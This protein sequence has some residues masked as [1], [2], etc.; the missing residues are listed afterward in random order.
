[1]TTHRVAPGTV[2][3]SV[4]PPGSK[5]Y[6][7]R[8]AVL[9]SQ[10]TAPVVLERPLVSEDTLATRRALVRLGARIARTGTNW[11]VQPSPSRHRSDRRTLV[12]DCGES[13]TTFRFLAALAAVRPGT[14]AL[15]GSRRL[16]ARPIEPLLETLRE[17]GARCRWLRG[18]RGLEITGPIRPGRFRLN[19]SVSSQFTSAL[20]LTLPFL[21]SP[22]RVDL[23]GDI[24][25][26]P[27]VAASRKMLNAF[28]LRVRGTGR[29]LAVPAPQRIRVRK[30]AIPADASS[31]A[32]WWVAAAITGGRIETYGVR[33][34]PPQADLRVL[35]VLRRCGVRVVRDSDG[36]RVGGRLLRGF[37][38]DLTEAPDLYPLLVVLAVYAPRP[39]EI[40]GAPHVISKESDR[41][42][43][44]IR[45]ATSF[46]ARARWSSGRL[47]IEPPS[48][49]RAVHFAGLRDHRL[50]MSAAVGALGAKGVSVIGDARAVR[51]SYPRFWS[52][53]H[54]LR[55]PR[56]R[57][58]A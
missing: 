30:V 19:A 6:T 5:S 58:A 33:L 22:S 13:G 20:L 31:A 43:G 40:V 11:E 48:V 24:V 36:V 39:S 25:S 56:R 4:H 46:G 45:L 51:K 9:A 2:V 18:A 1:M 28:G 37:R 3:G 7:H 41:R 54:A 17:H 57:T 47:R 16:M 8:A 49:P 27:Y 14:V 29:H 50:V 52:D 53:L 23:T 10:G 21:A 44:S 15:V 35:E 42:A 38:V 34:A 26:A 12:I 55:V 32:Y